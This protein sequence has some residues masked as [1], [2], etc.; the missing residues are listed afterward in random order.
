MRLRKLSFSEHIKLDDGTSMVSAT[1]VGNITNRNEFARIFLTRQY[2]TTKILIYGIESNHEEH[3]IRWRKPITLE[4]A[5]ARVQE[6]FKSVCINKLTRIL[7]IS[8]DNLIAMLRLQKLH[9]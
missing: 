1:I 5:K 3:Y 7:D 6:K 4:K 8:E 9:D 2:M